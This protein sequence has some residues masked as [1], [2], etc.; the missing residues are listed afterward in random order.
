MVNGS[1]EYWRTL[2]L[3]SMAFLKSRLPSLIF[4]GPG[5]S[6]IGFDASYSLSITAGA[7]YSIGQTFQGTGTLFSP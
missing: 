2:L 1:W 6:I 3:P 5:R 4:S 7:G